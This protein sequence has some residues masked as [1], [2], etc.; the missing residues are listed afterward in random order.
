[1]LDNVFYVYVYIDPRNFQEFY[2]G[3]GKEDRKFE[4]LHDTSDS[5]KT[6]IIKEIRKEGL[7]PVIK[8]IA[9]DLTE[10]QALLVEKTLIW[11]L[12]RHLTN[13]NSGHYAHN[14]RPQ[15]TLHKDLFGF[16]YQNGVYC[17]NVGDSAQTWRIWE[18]CRKYGFISAGQ[19]WQKWGSKICNLRPNDILCSYSSKHGY[20]GIGRVTEKACH[21][22]DFIYNGKLLSSSLSNPEMFSVEGDL[23]N[24]EFILKVDWIKT[25]SIEEATGGD[26]SVWRTRSMLASLETQPSTMAF[27]EKSFGF[28]FHDLLEEIKKAG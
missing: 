24:G 18:N 14:F 1:M 22:K 15:V 25:C 9:R 6:R 5:E 3:K 11:K 7:E 19:D 17:I 4:H 20:V 8:V 12:G 13:Q 27:L 10:D 26:I 2:Y 16:D 28:S 21:A 23:K